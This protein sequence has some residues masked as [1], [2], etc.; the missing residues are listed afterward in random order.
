MLF[1]PSSNFEAIRKNVAFLREIVGDGSTAAVFSRMLP[2]GGT[3]IRD[4]LAREGRLRGDLTHPDYV[5]LDPRINDYHRL[6]TIAVR[7]WIHNRGLS[8][9]LA[10][11]VDELETITRLAP[12]AL[13][14]DEYRSALRLIAAECNERL[15]GLVDDSSLAFERGDC[16]PLDPKPIADYCKA[17]LSKLDGLRSEFLT[18]NMDTLISSIIG[19]QPAHPVMMPQAH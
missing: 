19:A 4:T 11:S 5:F 10:N 8:Y 18:R 1:D 12:E 2:Y 7:P 16:T 6:L 3:P 9:S 17:N 13:G 15:L 14:C